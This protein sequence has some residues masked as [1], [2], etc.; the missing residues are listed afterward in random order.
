M[1]L[2]LSRVAAAGTD[3]AFL[4][5][6]P[7]RARGIT[8]VVG[9]GY[10]SS[11]HNLDFL[12]NFLAGHGFRVLS[13]D[14]PGHKLGASGGRLRSIDDLTDAMLAV[15]R[16]AGERYGDPI[17]VIGHSMGATTALR[18]CAADRRISGAISIATGSGRAAALAALRGK[19]TV[20]LRASYV[21]GL[22]LDEVAAQTED[23][24]DNALAGLA[25]RPALYIAA[26]RD[27]MV[28]RKSAEDLFERAPEPKTFAMIASDHTYAGEHARSVVLAWLDE[29]HPRRS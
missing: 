22:T 20:D 16:Y 28:S 26:D 7:R 5:Y 4:D 1:H 12:C 25:G 23:V 24:L 10:S 18:S 13:L 14:F 6:E 21:D 9:H 2:E 29:R 27:M 17:Y 11:K 3:I 8:L 15:V 19:V